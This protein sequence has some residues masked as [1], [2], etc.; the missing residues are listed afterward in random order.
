ML[1]YYLAAK[2]AT[3]ALYFINW[4]LMRQQLLVAARPNLI[5]MYFLWCSGYRAKGNTFFEF[6]KPAYTTFCVEKA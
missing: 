1:F 5:V 6:D 4:S 2:H 3:R